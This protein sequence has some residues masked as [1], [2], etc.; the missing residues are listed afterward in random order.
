MQVLGLNGDAKRYFGS[1][2]KE[3][4]DDRGNAPHILDE[5][6]EQGDDMPPRSLSEEDIKLIARHAAEAA[7]EAAGRSGSGNRLLIVACLGL[8]T[9]GAGFLSSSSIWVGGSSS[10][11]QSLEKEV[12]TLQEDKKAQDVQIQTYRERLIKL[13][14]KID[15][16][17]TP[18]RNDAK[19]TR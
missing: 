12:S 1:E 7:V 8:L 11:I 14:A 9:T 17:D 16:L 19:G 15:V 4:T 3:Y 5:E 10:K 2:H 6:F 18:R 13:E